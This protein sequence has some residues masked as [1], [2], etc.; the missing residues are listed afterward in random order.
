MTTVTDSEPDTTCPRCEQPLG[1]DA[2]GGLCPACLMQT[3]LAAAPTPGSFEPPSLDELEPL[4]PQFELLGLLGRGGMGAVYVARDKKLD[5]KVAIKV[6]PPVLADDLGF[7]ER[8]TREARAMAKLNHPHVVTI[9]DFG[10][11]EGCCYLVLELVEGGNL[12]ERLA[13]QAPDQVAGI[14][15]QAAEGLA[16][17]HE[18]GIVHR[19]V[20]PG[21][22]LVGDDGR[23]RLADF[24][25]AKAAVEGAMHS[26]V[27]T[28]TGTLQALGTPHYAA[29]EQI[30]GNEVD[31]RAD[32]YALGVV[33]YEALTGSLPLGR[34]PDPSATEGVDPAWDALILACLE[35]DPARRPGSALELLEALRALE[36]GEAP[37]RGPS[38]EGSQVSGLSRTV[39]RLGELRGYR[40]GAAEGREPHRKRRRTG[41]VTRVIEGSTSR[42]SIDAEPIAWASAGLGLLVLLAGFMPWVKI[43]LSAFGRGFA[44]SP[45]SGQEATLTAW[46]SNLDLGGLELPCWGIPIAGLGFL[47]LGGLLY[48]ERL[49]ATLAVHFGGLVVSG[50]SVLFLA[51]YGGL[52][53]E[54]SKASLQVGA[55]LSLIAMLALLGGSLRGVWQLVPRRS[56]APSRNKSKG[57]LDVTMARIRHRRAKRKVG[58]EAEASEEGSEPAVLTFDSED[59]LELESETELDPVEAAVEASEAQ[60]PVERAVEQSAA[61]RRRATGLADKRRFED[62][63]QK[64]AIFGAA[65][66]GITV[67]IL[68]AIFFAAG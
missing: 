63:E 51:V 3:A 12:R 48:F 68:L 1:E 65:L 66:G 36:A 18:R 49:R 37:S 34:F 53:L 43:K 60:D 39:A 7:T 22:I 26:L 59:G 15:R 67:V 6:L 62:T 23:V 2:P 10:E 13:G 28:L 41:S 5:R 57:N 46:A 61:R 58:Q 50:G 45:F 21:N 52:V 42:E 8:F 44:G 33:A 32:V 40:A 25:L 16:Y 4:L 31:A 64:V 30:E 56:S 54:S 17:A 55:V 35:R 20:K 14:L 19:D 47:I 38:D 9:H 11:V 29:P 24:G 27:P